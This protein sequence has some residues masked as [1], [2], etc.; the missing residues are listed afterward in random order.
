MIENSRKTKESVSKNSSPGSKRKKSESEPAEIVT[1]KFQPEKILDIECSGPENLQYLFYIQFRNVLKN[2]ECQFF[3][4]SNLNVFS[5]KFLRWLLAIFKAELVELS[6]IKKLKQWT[7]GRLQLL[8]DFCDR[9]EIVY[10]G[11]SA[12]RRIRP[13]RVYWNDQGSFGSARCDLDFNPEPKFPHKI[14]K[15]MPKSFRIREQ[16]E[17]S[18]SEKTSLLAENDRKLA[19]FPKDTFVAKRFNKRL[20]LCIEKLKNSQTTELRVAEIEQELAWLKNPNNQKF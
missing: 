18:K 13:A 11:L 1:V 8:K 2:S 19:S 12:N 17:T 9:N 14:S 6:D 5:Q 20:A 16:N 3:K 10:D 4:L 7:A 15:K